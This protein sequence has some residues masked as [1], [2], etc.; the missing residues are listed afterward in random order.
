MKRKRENEKNEFEP[1]SKKR[2]FD[3]LRTEYRLFDGLE[4]TK[5]DLWRS[6]NNEIEIGRVYE[7]PPFSWRNSKVEKFDPSHMYKIFMNVK[8]ETNSET[9]N[10]WCYWTSY[11]NIL[12]KVRDA[13]LIQDIINYLLKS[14]YQIYHKNNFLIMNYDNCYPYTW[15]N[16]EKFILKEFKSLKQEGSLKDV[17]TEFSLVVASRYRNEELKS[18]CK[19][20][21]PNHQIDEG[22]NYFYNELL[23][24]QPTTTT[25]L[26]MDE[27]N[28]FVSKE[29]IICM[30]KSP[31]TVVL[32]CKHKVVCI[33]CSDEL[34][35][36]GDFKKKCIVCQAKIEKI[37]YD[38]GKEL[39]Y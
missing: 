11:N 9:F 23:K 4:K 13:N 27:K 28:L 20:E 14:G 25:T 15:E 18:F 1:K 22:E 19:K 21:W 32:P 37:I 33:Q 31:S 2:K 34:E 36:K 24:E 17:S 12:V 35:K 26:E 3:P 6:R 39:N 7:K 29:C 16:R 30:E 10:W 8:N 38:N 5:D